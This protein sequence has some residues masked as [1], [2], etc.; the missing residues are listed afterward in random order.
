MH[1]LASDAEQADQVE[2]FTYNGIGCLCCSSSDEISLMILAV[3]S[4]LA[5]FQLCGSFSCF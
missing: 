1:Q 2:A 5:H 3:K 4:M